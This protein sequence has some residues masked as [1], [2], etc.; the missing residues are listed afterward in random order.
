MY[1]YMD[2]FCDI[3]LLRVV[4]TLSQRELTFRWLLSVEIVSR[5]KDYVFTGVFRYWLGFSEVFF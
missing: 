5:K 1:E 3:S 4:V 2:T